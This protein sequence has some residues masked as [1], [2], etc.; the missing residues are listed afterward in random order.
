MIFLSFQ[1]DKIKIAEL[2]TQKIVLLIT[3][4]K[5]FS[6]NKQLN[7]IDVIPSFSLRRLKKSYIYRYSENRK[8]STCKKRKRKQIF[9]RA[10]RNI[11]EEILLEKSIHL[12]FSSFYNKKT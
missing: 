6:K 4:S 8:K 5:L 11:N 9:K 2:K 12:I 3:L 7:L 10:K 1:I